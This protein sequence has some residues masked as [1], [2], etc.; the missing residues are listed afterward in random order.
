VSATQPP[1]DIKDIVEIVQG[2]VT[3]AAIVIAGFWTYIV[4]VKR[5]Q[6]YPRMKVQHE[7][8]HW[9]VSA[10]E[11]LLRVVERISNIGE[12]LVPLE[13][14]TVRV[15]QVRPWRD[16][17]LGTVVA[18]RERLGE[19]VAE[20]DWPVLGEHKNKW[21]TGD[22]EIEPTETDEV[23]YDLVVDKAVES[24]SVYTYV[25]NAYK[26]RDPIRPW[27]SREIGWNTT[28]VH[29]LDQ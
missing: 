26:K 4:F 6:R 25:K 16:D 14:V 12:V 21:R 15:Q 5:R 27:R 28:T 17:A 3:S 9:P 2:I 1:N 8:E 19:G 22:Q 20:L 7:V 23:L 10:D 29:Q 24:I 13:S 18:A 11:R